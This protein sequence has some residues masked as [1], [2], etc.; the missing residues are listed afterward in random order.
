MSTELPPKQIVCK[1]GHSF[2]SQQHSNWCAKCGRQLFY[3]ERD[4]RKS[5]FNNIYIMSLI[6][7]VF[8]FLV[9]FFIE[10]IVTPLLS[11]PK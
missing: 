9:Y 3:D 1:C 8:F 7:L 10:L 4:Q 2:D 6:A 5:R 11:I